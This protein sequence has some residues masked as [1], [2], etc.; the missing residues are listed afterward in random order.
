MLGAGYSQRMRILGIDPGLTVTGI[1]VINAD[2]QDCQHLHHGVVRTRP[3]EAMAD[4]LSAIQEAVCNAAKHWQ[5]DVAAIESSFV[6]NNARSA[7]ALGHARA[8]AM[9]GLAAA[10]L[11]VF[12]YAPTMVKQ[13]VAGYGRGDKAQIAEMVRLQLGMRETVRPS[14]AA[15]AL[16]V[17][18]T[19]W[20]HARLNFRQG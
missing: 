14:D 15:D 8:A 6:G 19:H 1:G 5:A 2:Q 4:R 17:A 10:G 11:E 16:G 18:I 13:T 20:A 7:M 9:L 3:A 12:E